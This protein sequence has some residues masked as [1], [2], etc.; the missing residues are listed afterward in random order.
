MKHTPEAQLTK[1]FQT[2]TSTGPGL[3][4]LAELVE[5]DTFFSL[6][7]NNDGQTP[8]TVSPRRQNGSRG[9]HG[10]RGNPRSQKWF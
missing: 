2:K 7:E 8:T 10:G 4:N 9:R 6:E 5:E 1:N 3:K